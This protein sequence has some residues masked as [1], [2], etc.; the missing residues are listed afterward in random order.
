MHVKKQSTKCFLQTMSNFKAKTDNIGKEIILTGM[1][2]SYSTTFD[3]RLCRT[4][5]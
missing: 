4:D 3:T 1:Q 5:P 2:A